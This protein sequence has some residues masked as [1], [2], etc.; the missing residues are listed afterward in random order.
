MSGPTCCRTAQRSSRSWRRRSYAGEP[1][2][3]RI[4]NRDIR[5]GEKKWQWVKRGV[6]LR[7]EVGPRDVAERQS[8][9]SAGA[10]WPA[11]AVDCRATEFVAQRRQDARRD[12]ASAASTRAVQAP[13]GRR[14]CEIDSLKEFEAYFTP[15]NEERP[16]IHG[17]LAYSHFVESPEMDEKLKALK[18]T[19][20]CVPLDARGRA[21]QVHLHR[22]AE[23]A[24]AA[25]LRRR[26]ES[27]SAIESSN[28]MG[29]IH[30]P[31]AGAAA[32]RREQ[33]V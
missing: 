28:S 16:E 9:R 10:T 12:S 6:P 4:D 5:G 20:R 26:I 3:V 29:D 7:V 30:E 15:K 11:K 31:D 23:H 21:G 8:D 27:A 19:V 24:S 32:R 14:A 2:R 18:V 33:S 22:P 17:G 25:C 13:R 1:I